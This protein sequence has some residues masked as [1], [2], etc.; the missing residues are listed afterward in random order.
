[1]TT[2]PPPHPAAALSDAAPSPTSIIGHSTSQTPAAPAP[3]P[4]PAPAVA[5]APAPAFTPAPAIAPAVAPAP[6]A[7]AAMPLENERKRPA[8][9]KNS[10][11]PQNVFL[12]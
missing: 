7:Q 5:P 2:Q 9:Q 3:A 1:M 4:A 10:K 8:V 6:S 11:F 12:G